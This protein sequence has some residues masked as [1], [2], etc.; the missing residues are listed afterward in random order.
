VG[1]YKVLSVIGGGGMGTVYLAYDE[2]LGRQIALKVLKPSTSDDG[3]RAGSDCCAKHGPLRHSITPTSVRS[4]MSARS[5]AMPWIAM[6]FVEGRSLQAMIPRDGLPPRAV[7]R[8]G[9]QIATPSPTR[10]NA[11]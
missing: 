10:T 2:R 3:N 4:S 5:T 7:L 9:A 8:L 1:P 6:E 11:V